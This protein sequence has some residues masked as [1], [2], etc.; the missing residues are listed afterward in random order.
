MKIVLMYSSCFLSV[1]GKKEEDATA[2]RSEYL[3]EITRI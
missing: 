2:R 3:E 1:T